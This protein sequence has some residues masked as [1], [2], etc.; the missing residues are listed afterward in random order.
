MATV[1][2]PEYEARVLEM[3]GDPKMF[4]RELRAFRKDAQVLSSARQHL[5]A[6]Y[7]KQW[8]GIHQ[9]KVVAH[10]KTLPAVVAR[11]EKLGVPRGRAIVRYI[12]KKPRKM[13]L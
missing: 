12:D 2:H 3:L 4:D 5:I 7:P 6:Q 9:G 8:I 1:Q 10:A 11:L 13:I